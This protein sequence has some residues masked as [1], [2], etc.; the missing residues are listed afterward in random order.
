MI[1]TYC[2]QIPH[3]GTNRIFAGARH[4]IP[5]PGKIFL[6]DARHHISVPDTVYLC[7][8]A[9]LSNHGAESNLFGL[10][11]NWVREWFLLLRLINVI[12]WSWEHQSN[13][14]DNL[15]VNWILAFPFC[16]VFLNYKEPSS[17]SRDSLIIFV[18]KFLLALISPGN[19]NIWSKSWWLAGSWHARCYASKI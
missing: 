18:F 8:A 15:L 3:I 14:P 16:L 6:T 4:L 17:P 9:T 13:K 5:V 1:I 7:P 12:C 2:Y 10:H 19:S 11:N